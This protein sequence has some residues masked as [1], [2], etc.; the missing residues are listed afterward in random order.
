M[1]AICSRLS[2]WALVATIVPTAAVPST[3]FAR[4]VP[5]PAAAAAALLRAPAAPTAAELRQALQTAINGTNEDPEVHAPALRNALDQANAH[6]GVVGRDPGLAQLRIEGLLYLARAQLV[7]DET[8]AAAAS[9]DEAIRVSGG[10]VPSI[11]DFGPSLA[12]LYDER[13]A[14][15]ELRQVGA[16]RVTCTGGPCRVFLD[17]RVLGT[18]A[19]ISASGVP[20]GAHVL[21]IEPQERTPPEP[22]MQKDIVITDDSP[23]MEF[24]FEVPAAPTTTGGGG[25]TPAPV[26]GDSGRKLPRWAGILGMTLGGVALAGGVFAI[27]I[28]GRCPDLSDSTPTS[29]DA[30]RDVH[31]SLLSGIVVTSAGVAALTGFGVAFGIGEAKDKRHAAGQSAG[32]K[33]TAASVQMSWRF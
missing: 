28:D 20:L 18:G 19:S 27:A 5:P 22:F 25:G 8:A 14:S 21:R 4:P 17:G 30:C 3:V 29:G 6:P 33:G 9:V 12:K 23:S 31:N 26:A 11:G 7:L 15:P 24:T 32:R 1:N 16:V 13:Q 10:S 2:R